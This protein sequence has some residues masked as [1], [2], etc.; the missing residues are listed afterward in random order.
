MLK[1]QLYQDWMLLKV[2]FSWILILPGVNTKWSFIP[3]SQNFNYLISWLIQITT[4]H[5]T[6][7]HIH[8]NHQQIVWIHTLIITIYPYPFIF[9]KKTKKIGLT[10][11]R[12]R[13]SDAQVLTVLTATTTSY[14]CRKSLPH[15]HRQQKH[16]FE[17]NE[18]SNSELNGL[19][20]RNL[21]FVWIF[22][23]FWSVISY[24]LVH[25]IYG[26]LCLNKICSIGDV[27]PGIIFSFN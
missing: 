10:V 20:V 12:M 19:N 25:I 17:F 7:H 13:T 4:Q 23:Y 6:N 21:G 2:K 15:H 16:Y 5:E 14:T 3:G 27:F 11:I 24:Q 22:H 1:R 8:H 18:M 9:L 26:V